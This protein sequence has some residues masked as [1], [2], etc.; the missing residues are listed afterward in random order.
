MH[1]FMYYLYYDI[2]N[3]VESCLLYYGYVEE[4]KPVNLF[5]FIK[6]KRSSSLFF[7]VKIILSV[8]FDVQI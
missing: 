7:K 5:D 2:K 1:L 3:V 6:C 4:K 8:I